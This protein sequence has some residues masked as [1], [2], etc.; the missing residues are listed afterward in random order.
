MPCYLF[1]CDF[2]STDRRRTIGCVAFLFIFVEESMTRSVGNIC[3]DVLN[4]NVPMGFLNQYTLHVCSEVHSV[5]GTWN[6]GIEHG[7]EYSTQH[8]RE[9]ENQMCLE[10]GTLHGAPLNI[11]YSLHECHESRRM[12]SGDEFQ[13]ILPAI[14]FNCFNRD[15]SNNVLPKM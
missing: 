8:G 12:Y 9:T 7:I 1:Q 3:S 11:F 5:I 14:T 10:K 2:D 6:H 4:S 15:A 13:L